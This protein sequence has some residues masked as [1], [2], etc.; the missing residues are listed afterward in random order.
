MQST[1][2]FFRDKSTTFGS[3]IGVSSILELSRRSLRGSKTEVLKRK[4]KGNKSSWSSWLWCVCWR[5]GLDA[6]T[7]QN[8]ASL[9]D[10]LAEE[11]KAASQTRRNQSLPLYGPDDEF[12]L[13]Q[14]QSML[15]PNSLF[16][17]GSIAPPPGCLTPSL[18]T[19]RESRGLSHSSNG[20]AS[21]TQ[22]FTCV[23]GHATPG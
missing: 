18:E 9:A 5:S 11:R 19:E 22:L 20:V 13:A 3:L 7:Q 8:G 17:N 2:S 12:L 6:D 16:V 15:H 4:K 14:S 10:F 23:C 1:G 21:L